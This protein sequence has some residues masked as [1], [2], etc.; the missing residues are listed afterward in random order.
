MKWFKFY[1]QDWLTD[2]KILSLSMED[3][4]CYI[5]F[6][7]LIS[8]E[9]GNKIKISEDILIHLSRIPDDPKDNNNPYDNAIGCLQRFI[10]NK[11]I[12][13]DNNGA[14]SCVNF[15]KRQGE[16]LTGYERVK[17][18]RENKKALE[19][20]DKF[21]NADTVNDNIHDVIIDNARVDKKR[22]DNNREE[23]KDSLSSKQVNKISYLVKI[24]QEDIELFTSKY[25]AT[26]QQIIS[27][28]EDLKLYCESKGKRYKNYKSFL[29]N[30][31]KKDF[32]QKKP[33]NLISS[34]IK[35]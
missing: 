31:I 5:T 20:K 34:E 30:A 3:R 1:G 18:Y 10:D 22:T 21:N 29:E 7:C 12:M 16:N 9:D 13:R 33:N 26:K 2:P 14:L 15:A 17:R 4:L 35:L 23:S 27:K 6:L 11:M 24:P 19:N 28:G 25:G 8:A 32:G